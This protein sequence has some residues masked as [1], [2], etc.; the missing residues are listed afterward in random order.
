MLTQQEA[1]QA[2]LAGE[3]VLYRKGDGDWL[4]VDDANLFLDSTLEFRISPKVA[5]TDSIDI[6]LSYHGKMHKG[7]TYYLPDLGSKSYYATRAWYGLDLE[8]ILMKRGLIFL[9]KESAVA[10]SEAAIK[11]CGGDPSVGL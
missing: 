8:R 11:L 9:D 5:V 4:L 7:Q 1:F 3:K 6:P 2:K 10:Y